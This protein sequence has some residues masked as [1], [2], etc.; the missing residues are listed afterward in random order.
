M[1]MDTAHLSHRKLFFGTLQNLTLAESGPAVQ[2]SIL[3]IPDIWQFKLL[4]VD[5]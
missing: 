4:L 5:I 2:I 1:T 3:K